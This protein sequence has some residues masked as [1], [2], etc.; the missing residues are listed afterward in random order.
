M[1]VKSTLKE[2]ITGIL[3]VVIMITILQFTIT[4]VDIELYI[5]FLWSTVFVIVGLFLFLLGIEYGFEQAGESIGKAVVKSGKL[6]WILFVTILLGFGVTMLEPDV[7]VFSKQ[8][9][10]MIESVNAFQFQAVIAVGVGLFIGLAF[11]RIFLKIKMRYI[12][13]LGYILA[14]I[15]IPFCSID[16]SSAAF[17]AGGATTGALTVPFMLSLAIGISSMISKD[18]NT[19]N[20]FGIIGIASLGPILSILIMGVITR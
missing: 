20:S 13:L 2:I 9:E 12:V 5:R 10:F 6:R 7:Q 17:D 1:K 18:K 16:L 14:F 19:S 4:P 3:P 11:L 15:L 8:A